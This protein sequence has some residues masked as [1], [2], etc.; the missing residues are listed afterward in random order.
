MEGALES[1]YRKLLRGSLLANA[2]ALMLFADYVAAAHASRVATSPASDHAPA[3]PA[4]PIVVTSTADIGAGT[5]RDAIGNASSGDTIIF[6]LTLP[7]VITLTTGYLD[8]SKNLTISGS[9]TPSLLVID[10][11]Q[12]SRV[13]RIFAGNVIISGLTIRNGKEST[14]GFAGGGIYNSSALTRTNSIVI[15]NASNGNGG[16][17]YHDGTMLTLDNVS[18]I[19]N[20]SGLYE[21]G[22]LSSSAGIITLMNTT[23]MSNTSTFGGGIESFS[24]ATLI[25]V[26]MRGN[27][28]SGY[29]GGI[30]AALAPMTLTNS[31]VF[32]NTAAQS[33]GGIAIASI[34]VTITNSAIFSNTGAGGTGGGG[35]YDQGGPLWMTNVTLSGNSAPGNSGGALTIRL[36]GSGYLTNVTVHANTAGFG[37]GIIAALGTTTTLTNTILSNNTNGNCSVSGTMFSGGHNL[38]D[39]DDCGLTASGDM[40]NTNPLLGPL[41][42]NGGATL[43]HALLPGSPA[44]DHGTNTGCP[45]TD[46]RGSHRPVDGDANGSAICDIGAYEAPLRLFLPLIKK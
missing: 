4:A 23:F 42:N 2:L 20:T 19:S 39:A 30:N 1:P 41:A 14:A 16:G 43:T 29:G 18:V 5:L 10:G 12:S 31:S 21:G 3:L 27:T 8:I 9:V 33:G 13:F 15:N 11:N 46:Q 7:A 24:P 28:A 35:V 17:I 37:A 40:T 6:S 22:G 45:S 32:S 25:S 26:T 44:T 38:E 36:S 34:P